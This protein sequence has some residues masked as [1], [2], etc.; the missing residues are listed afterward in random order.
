MSIS[1]TISITS[2]RWQLGGPPGLEEY[3]R[4]HI[5]G[6]VYVDLD[7]ELAAPPGPGRHPL[8]DT[9]AF[10]VAMRA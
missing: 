1:S 2:R 8:P 9:R 6:A 5:P 10:E 3:R 4:G 7:R